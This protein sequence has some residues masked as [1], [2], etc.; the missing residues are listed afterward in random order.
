MAR[1]KRKPDS[2][3]DEKKL[4]LAKTIASQSD[5]I[6][7]SYVNI[8]NVFLKG[9]RFVSSWF[10]KILF[11]QRYARE[12]ALILAII[13]YVSVNS[14]DSLTITNTTSQ[15]K[16]FNNLP[17]TVEVNNSVYEVAGLPETV[18]M[19]VIGD[20]SDIQGITGEDQRVVANL[21][22][23]GEGIHQVKLQVEGLS[24]RVESI[25]EPST[26]NVTISKKISKEYSIGYDFVNTSNMDQIYALGI[27]DFDQDSVIVRASE[28][29]IK[30][31]SIVKA[32]IDVSN[33][34]GNFSAEAPLVA[35]DQN[36]DRLAV[37]I[38]PEKVVVS[39]SVTTPQKDVPIYVQPVGTIP[40]DKAIASY[41]IDHSIVTLYGPQDVLDGINQINISLPV[42]NFNSEINTVSMPINVPSGVRKK[43]VNI[44]SITVTLADKEEKIIEDV[45]IEYRNYNNSYTITI[46]EEE[47]LYADVIVLGA[48]EV[49]ESENGE[50]VRVYIDFSEIPEGANGVYDLP[51]HVE[52]PNSMLSYSLER[53]SIRVNITP[54]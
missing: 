35:Y 21:Q 16:T 13:L 44:V 24:S 4:E 26:V 5:K 50:N 29:T 25:I 28:Q 10:D 6:A 1:N 17:L 54:Q 22:G 49:L 18:N 20:L 43:S 27:P 33:V 12:I 30:S 7:K 37:D 38:V 32:L 14:L 48:G 2:Q 39:V 46:D 15:V 52:G 19:N 9:F 40:N 31:I 45:A 36:G 47:Q 53:E 41:S 8:E 3:V 23:L 11:N 42:T 34:S 51:L